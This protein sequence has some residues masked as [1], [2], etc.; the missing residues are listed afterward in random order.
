[1][2]KKVIAAAMAAVIGIG[3]MAFFG[4]KALAAETET[5]VP[6]QNQFLG[7]GGSF[8]GGMFGG[9]RMS[10]GRGMMGGQAGNYQDLTDAQ[11]AD[12]Q[13]IREEMVDL[14]DEFYEETQ[15]VRDA[16][17]GALEEA[18]KTKILAAYP[19]FKT[20]K[21]ANIAKLEDLRNKMHEILGTT[22]VTPR[23]LEF[24]AEADALIVELKATDDQTEIKS[25][26]DEIL[27]L[28]GRGGRGGRGG[29]RGAGCGFYNAPDS[30]S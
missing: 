8:G 4:S 3:A 28:F 30:D 21:E 22:D 2:N 19:D 16:L 7:R 25:I 26:A 15:E 13:K 9:G 18:D 20:Q 17:V 10:G 14:R 29:F 23:G 12:L 27:G 24:I 11:V 6:Q 1:M 5:E